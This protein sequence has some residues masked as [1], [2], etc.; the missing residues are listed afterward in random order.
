M[1]KTMTSKISVFIFLCPLFCFSQILTGRVVDKVTQ[2]PIETVAVYFNNTT[3]GAT[4]NG[5]GEFAISYSD[6]VQ[7]SLV[8][9][10]LGYEKVLISDFRNQ[11]NIIVELVEAENILD[12]VHL[13][14]DDG[15]TRRQKLRLFRKEFLGTS[16]FGKSCKILNEDD[17]ILKYDKRTK[18]LY[19]SSNVALKIENKALQYD[20]SYDLIDFEV[21]FR[22]AN[23]N[24]R[25]FT[26]KSVLY[27][28]TSFYTDLNAE[29]KEKIINN[30]EHTYKGSIQH[31]MRSL[32]NKNLKDEGYWIF[33]DKF[34]VDEWSY[35]SIEDDINSDTK[36]VTLKETVSIL[37]KK[38]QQ[39]E[40][41]VDIDEFFVDTYGNYSPV[42]G[43]YFSGSMGDQRLGDT[44]PLGYGISQ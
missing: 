35:F 34:R 11:N 37:Y 17:L 40:L 10:Y 8:F 2:Q 44:L 18:A 38:K 13:E 39:S 6:A 7:S 28:G 20:I 43:V 14:Y 1:G 32:Y 27:L 42:I 4:T 5:N 41:Q 24:T 26:V 33:H 22:Y 16:K 30:R 3:I 19:A 31:F 29:K 36:K 12:E 9:S 25:E 23:L 15:L 21:N